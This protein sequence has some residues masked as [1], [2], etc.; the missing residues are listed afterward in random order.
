MEDQSKL[1]V[2]IWKPVVKLHRIDSSLQHVTEEDNV[3]DHQQLRNQDRNSSLGQQVHTGVLQKEEQEE[4]EPLQMKKEQEEP[5]PPQIKVEQEEPEPPQIKVEQ[6]ELCSSQDEQQL[7]LKEETD[8]FMVTVNYEESD[9][10]ESEPTS[11]QLFSA[12]SPLKEEQGLDVEEKPYV[13]NTCGKTFSD[14][15]M[16]NF[17]QKTHQVEKSFSCETCLKSFARRDRLIRHMITHTGEKPYSCEICGD[18]FGL[19]NDLVRH[20]R[21]HTGSVSRGERTHISEEAKV[22]LQKA[23]KEGMTRVG[24]PLVGVA[25][26]ATGLPPFVIDNWIGN[27][28]RKKPS[29]SQPKN[30]LYTKDLSGYNLFCSDLLKN[31]GSLKDVT[32]KWSTLGE[33]QKRKYAEEAAAL[34]VQRTSDHLSPEMRSLKVKK[35]LKQIKIEVASLEKLGME[36]GVMMFDHQKPFLEVLEVSSK[37]ASSFFDRTDVLDN[38]ALH[39]KGNSSYTSAA[40]EPVDSM[41]KKVQELFNRKY[42]EAGGRGRLPY[43]S[44]QNESIIINA[45]GL[46]DGITLKKPCHYGRKQLE[47]ILK[48]AEQISFKINEKTVEES[49]VTSDTGVVIT[50]DD[51]GRK[52]R[53]P[54]VEDILNA[55]CGN[56]EQSITEPM[57][58]MEVLSRE[59]T[60]D[61]TTDVCNICHCLFSDEKKNAKKKWREWRRCNTCEQWS[62]L[63]CGFKKNLSSLS[64]SQKKPCYVFQSEG[65]T[66]TC[67]TLKKFSYSNYLVLCWNN[68]M[69]S[70]CPKCSNLYVPRYCPTYDISSFWLF[71][72]HGSPLCNI[73][74]SVKSFLFAAKM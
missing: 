4:P 49:V 30:K 52:I 31:K 20:M 66:L 23:Y 50:A 37:G 42:N 14:L 60:S 3:L 40:K 18:R 63:A 11:T 48:N 21:K 19:K 72:V 46:P 32:Q 17:H 6:A 57:G 8:I 74:R 7:D 28:R 55:M 36:T 13:C 56:D 54:T 58:S 45:S 73:F 16:L 22:F 44:I 24:S 59:P 10:S 43:I 39:F 61:N 2:S 41:V 35:H 65:E 27:Y 25:S 9:S 1:L 29:S 67:L 64:D 53:T 62:H 26:Q 5:E 71:T 69:V 70:H 33:V 34:K 15:S 68:E 51:P 38:F 12:S 47:V